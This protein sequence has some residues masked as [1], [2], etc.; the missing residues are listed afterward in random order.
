M[1]SLRLKTSVST[2]ETILPNSFIINYKLKITHYKL[3]KTSH[4]RRVLRLYFCSTQTLCQS[5]TPR[6]F[7]S[8]YL[9]GRTALLWRDFVRTLWISFHNSA[10]LQVSLADYSLRAPSLRGLGESEVPYI[11]VSAPPQPHS[12]GG[13]HGCGEQQALHAAPLCVP[14]GDHCRDDGKGDD[15]PYDAVDDSCPFH[16]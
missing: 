8:I 4:P 1:P 10:A 14:R 3:L 15:R 13:V 9:G 7:L 11:T 6:V 2:M 16:I 12:H 5:L